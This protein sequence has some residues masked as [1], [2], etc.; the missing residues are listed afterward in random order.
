MLLA[1]ALL[2]PLAVLAQTLP[3]SL[4]DPKLDLREAGTGLLRYWGLQIYQA[5]LWVSNGRF[6]IDQPFA[7]GMRYVRAFSGAA[8]A[9][10]SSDEIRRLNLGTEAQRT[11]WDEAMRRV[12]PEIKAG[13]ELLGMHWPQKG[14][15]FFANGR[16]LGVIE[17]PAFARAFFAIWFDPRTRSTELRS[18][19]L[20]GSQ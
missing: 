19:L 6:N 2:A 9:Q 7:L 5:R 14:L 16:T 20:A 4:A 18:A 12:I 8:I 15:E 11:Q 1:A 3:L 17:D 10:S 13:D